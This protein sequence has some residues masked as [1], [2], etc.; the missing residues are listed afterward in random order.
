VYEGFAEAERFRPS[1]IQEE[2][3]D[4]GHLGRKSGQGFYRYEAGT[5]REPMPGPAD[6]SEA[7]ADVAGRI[8]LAILA[9]AWR[10][11]GDGIATEHDIDTALHLGAGHHIG[12]FARTKELGGPAALVAALDAIPLPGPR[13]EIPS[14]LLETA[15]H[16]RPSAG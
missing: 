3:V 1:R 12:P 4:E 15:N 6:N 2:L 9:E 14:L 13:F 10:A 16:A 8:E 7:A 5:K 11:L